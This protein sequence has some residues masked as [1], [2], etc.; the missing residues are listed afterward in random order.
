GMGCEV[1]GRLGRS[2]CRLDVCDIEA[3]VINRGLVARISHMTI[4]RWLD[5]DAI[6]RWTHRSWIFPR[7][8]DFELKA[9]RVPDLYAREFEDGQLKPDE[10]VISS[11]EKTSIQARIRCHSSA[12]ANSHH[13]MLVEHEYDRGGSLAYIAAWDV[14]QTLRTPGGDHRHRASRSPR[15]PGH[16]RR[17]LS[18]RSPR[19]LGARQRQ[20]APRYRRCLTLAGSS[21]ELGARAPAPPCQLVESS[22]N[23][24]LDPPAQSPYAGGHGLTR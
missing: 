13:P 16:D 4:W 19:L 23:L 24:L 3:E 15:G 18:L 6:K 9:A 12:A 1:A 5:E 17:A 22:G 8:S 2:F 10:F 21:Q 11:D 20:L 14:H 7:D